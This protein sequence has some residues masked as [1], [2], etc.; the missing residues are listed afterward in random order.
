MIAFNIRTKESLKLII[1][2]MQQEIFE[3]IK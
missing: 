2:S 3:R 1:L